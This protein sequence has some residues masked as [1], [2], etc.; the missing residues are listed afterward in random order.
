MMIMGTA[1]SRMIGPT[2]YEV[3]AASPAS[4]RPMDRVGAA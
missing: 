1:V 2:A 3:A 4:V